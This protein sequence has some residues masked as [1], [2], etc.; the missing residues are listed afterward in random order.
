M[1]Y[2]STLQLSPLDL[3][4]TVL[5]MM[6]TRIRLQWL[7]VTT[8]L[9]QFEHDVLDLL[10]LI[11]RLPCVEYLHHQMLSVPDN[12]RLVRFMIPLSQITQACFLQPYW[13]NLAFYLGANRWYTQPAHLRMRL[14]GIACRTLCAL[15]KNRLQALLQR[16]DMLNNT[17]NINFKS[18]RRQC[19]LRQMLTRI[20]YSHQW[21][22]NG[23]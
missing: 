19:R 15:T 5:D 23:G 18:F 16:G 3:F 1:F 22:L 20:Q 14:Q 4:L 17:F 21:R 6:K 12:L 2:L 11:H 9:D 10:D 7:L 8:T 13:S